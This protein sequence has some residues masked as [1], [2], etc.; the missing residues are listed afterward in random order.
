MENNNE[1][2]FVPVEDLIDKIEETPWYHISSDGKLAEGANSRTDEPLYKA[3]D[4]KKAVQSAST[5]DLTD[6]RAKIIQSFFEEVNLAL[7]AELHKALEHSYDSE[8]ECAKREI[9]RALNST[10]STLGQ[11]QKRHLDGESEIAN[12]AVEVER[13]RMENEKL[14]KENDAW[15]V[16][17]EIHRKS[18]EGWKLLYDGDTDALLNCIH[19]RDEEIAALEG[20]L[21]LYKEVC[22]ELLIKDHHAVGVLRGEETAYIPE[23]LAKVYKGMAVN[24]AK[25]GTAKSILT[26][27]ILIDHLERACGAGGKLALARIKELKEEHGVKK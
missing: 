17:Q 8:S 18:N 6:A 16:M 13:L 21:H 20:K 24:T 9:R 25:R 2:K 4:I 15:K 14:V 26:D 23:K 1:R 19:A 11:I 27:K 7:T 3:A 5:V 12:L 10:M 22:G